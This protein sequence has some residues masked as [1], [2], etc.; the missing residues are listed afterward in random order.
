MLH[1]CMQAYIYTL[2]NLLM[3]SISELMISKPRAVHSLSGHTT[4][5]L[6]CE[7]YLAWSYLGACRHKLIIM[8]LLADIFK[9]TDTTITCDMILTS[10]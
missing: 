2:S 9:S 10:F 1:A 3:S 7:C 6:L 4:K 8:Q 5:H